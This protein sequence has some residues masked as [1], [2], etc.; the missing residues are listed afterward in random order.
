MV[1]FGGDGT[2]SEVVD[3]IMQSELNH[4]VSMGILHAGTGEPRLMVVTADT[5]SGPRAYVGLAFSY[6]ETIT[7]NWRRLNDVEWAQEIAGGDWL[8]TEVFYQAPLY[9]YFLASLYATVGEA[10]LFVRGVQAGLG[11]LSCGLLASAA[12]RFFDRRVGIV[13]GVLLAA[14][15]PTLF[16]DTLI[17]KSVLDLFLCSLLLWVLAS[18]R[19]SPSFGRGVAAGASVPPAPC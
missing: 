13:T 10:P 14:Y 2:H 16:F 3:G 18:G 19:R 9:P 15:P 5:C 8:G 11:A 1:S 17:Q 7:E 4:E 12:A 6:G